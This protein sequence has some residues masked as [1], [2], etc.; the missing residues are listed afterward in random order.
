M[1][2]CRLHFHENLGLS[3]QL[4]LPLLFLCQRGHLLTSCQLLLLLF[5]LP[6][7]IALKRAFL[8]VHCP[9]LTY[10]KVDWIR[11]SAA[12]KV[13]AEPSKDPLRV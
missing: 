9:S 4:D 7:V 2:H 12:Y 5:L 1:K 8:T 10:S 11:G 13:C 6:F 3:N